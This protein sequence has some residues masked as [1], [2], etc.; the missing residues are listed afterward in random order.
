MVSPFSQQTQSDQRSDER[1][2]LPISLGSDP[3]GTTYIRK[4][5]YL[6]LSI[7]TL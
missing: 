5:Y 4:G 3:Y 6:K 7:Y 1:N 2:V